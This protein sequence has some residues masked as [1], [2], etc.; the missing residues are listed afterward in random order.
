L[1][2]DSTL[3]QLHGNFFR[4][5]LRVPVA[6]DTDVNAAAYGELLWGAAK[7]L[8]DFIYVTVGTGIGGGIFSNGSL[9]HGLAH[10]ELGHIK[11][12]REASDSFA[13]ICPYHRDCIEGMASGPAMA[14][15]WNVRTEDLPDDHE[16]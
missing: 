10:P 9:V 2:Y 14:K 4:D 15:R 13:G 7:G 6:F 16:A 12:Q 8:K 5:E 11:V 1:K 3:G